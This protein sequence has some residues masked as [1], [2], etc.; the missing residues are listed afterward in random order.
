MQAYKAKKSLGNRKI[1]S[2]LNSL[3]ANK[4][5]EREQLAES[6]ISRAVPGEVEPEKIKVV[7]K[8]KGNL[9]EI[10]NAITARG[11]KM[12]R[13]RKDSIVADVPF[14]KIEDMVDSVPGIGY[15]RLPNKFFPMETI[16][17]ISEG[18][19]LT[20]ASSSGYTG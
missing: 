7:F 14:D 9:D 15:A 3:I 1:D 10:S 17:T 2:R 12:L 8:T 6:R 11:G 18:V 13:G 19:A 16:E 20:G 4:K 5:A